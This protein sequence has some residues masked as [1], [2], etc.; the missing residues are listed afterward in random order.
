MTMNFRQLSTFVGIYEEGSFNR[1]ATRLNATQSGLSM[2]IK[3]LEDM[4]GTPLF[5]RSARGV[6]PTYAGERLYDTAVDI[7]YRLEGAK[8]E[9][10]NLSGT[11]SGPVR[12]GLMPTFTR[13]VLVP[14]MNRF[15]TD[16]PN[17]DVT[18][19]EAYSAALMDRLAEGEVDFVVVPQDGGRRGMRSRKLGMDRE[20]LVC[21]PNGKIPHLTPVRLADMV[22]LRLVLPAKGN[23]RR[24]R[25]DEFIATN[26]LTVD[27]I[28]DMDAMFATL[29]LVATSD[30]ATVLPATIC[31]KDIDG[32]DRWLHPLT[33]PELTVGYVM[34]EPAR[35]AMSRAAAQFLRYLEEE[36]ARSDAE[37]T[38]LLS[39]DKGNQII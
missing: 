1:A 21:R 4:L 11:I 34:V 12:I 8:A 6:T 26:G 3:S 29:E 36:Y 2:Q 18:V 37:W 38:A 27:K 14:A 39:P 7:L 33:G 9:L 5:E 25:L 31:R 22:P 20:F 17:V 32:R 13:G 24:D 28:I 30:Y 23:A 16:Y 35:K 19:V 10:R 15:I